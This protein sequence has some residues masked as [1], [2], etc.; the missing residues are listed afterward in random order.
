MEKLGVQYMGFKD[1]R[2]RLF[3]ESRQQI[4]DFLFTLHYD[5]IFTQSKHDIHSDHSTLGLEAE[6]AFKHRNLVTFTGT[7]N[8]AEKPD[9]FVKLERK[10][11]DTKM[12]A[13]KCY[14]SQRAK[15]YM[16]SDFIWSNS[17]N[18]G[19]M[20]GTKFAEAFKVVNLIQ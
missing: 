16:K 5:F 6:R 1:F 7:W 11:I 3:H 2:T 10:H 18:N 15:D 12:E 13:L 14:E 4:L 8:H 17:M 9:Y 19:V 20:C